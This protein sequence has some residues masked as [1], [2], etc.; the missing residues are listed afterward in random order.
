MSMSQF[1]QMEMKAFRK[2]AVQSAIVWQM[3]VSLFNWETGRKR[4]IHG[5]DARRQ[6]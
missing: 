6:Q 2:G 4:N 5:R 1:R 3:C